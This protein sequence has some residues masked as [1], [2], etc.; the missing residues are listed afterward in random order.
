MNNKQ[1]KIL[2]K[3][4]K[5]YGVKHQ[6]LVVQEECAELIQAISKVLRSD[7]KQQASVY[8]NLIEE[9]AD[10]EI[11]SKQMRIIYGSTDIDEAMQKKTQRLERRLE[12]D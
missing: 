11:M 10:V 3:A 6:M 8:N 4:I 12:N 2:R 7:V 9:L 1:I 5:K